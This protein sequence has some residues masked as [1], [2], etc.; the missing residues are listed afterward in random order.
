MLLRLSMFVCVTSTPS[1]SSSTSGR[2][3]ARRTR[4]RARS[5]ARGTIGSAEQRVVAASGA[6]PRHGQGRARARRMWNAHMDRVGRLI[7]AHHSSRAGACWC[8]RRH[9]TLW[10]GW[11]IGDDDLSTP[12]MCCL[13]AC[14]M[15]IPF[16]F[17]ED[18]ILHVRQREVRFR[19]DRAFTG[20][21]RRQWDKS[22]WPLQVRRAH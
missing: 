11:S 15:E 14:V 4:A 5:L 19:S 22:Y 18:R 12:P 8:L 3:G 10:G 2:C 9:D 7:H 17:R 1:P 21:C 13:H 6:G 16:Q 20:V